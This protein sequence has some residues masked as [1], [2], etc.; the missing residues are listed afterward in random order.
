MKM[1]FYKST[2]TVDIAAK[3]IGIHTMESFD[4]RGLCI[5]I[6]HNGD[7]RL[8]DLANEIAEKIVKA[9]N[10]NQEEA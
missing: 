1:K 2:D 5:Q 6:R 7:K 9:L 8:F 10:E 4:N 3:S